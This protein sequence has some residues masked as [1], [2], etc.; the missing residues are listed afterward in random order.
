MLFP[1]GGY[2][3]A[4]NCNLYSMGVYFPYDLSGY[5]SA[6]LNCVRA[7]D[8]SGRSQLSVPEGYP[9]AAAYM[10]PLTTGGLA[11]VP[12]GAA[13]PAAT[14]SGMG[15][16]T[17]SL[18]GASTE[19]QTLKGLGNRTP[20]LS[21]GSTVD[22]SMGGGGSLSAS[23]KPGL[24]SAIDIEGVVLE[25]PIEGAYSAKQLLRIIAAILA[26]KVSGGPG[27]PVFRDVN[28][29]KNRVSGTADADG[30]R[31]AVTLDPD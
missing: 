7:A 30:N 15:T 24:V 26:G 2:V 18:S 31:T 16:V 3:D 25:T 10:P 11:A 1:Q 28:D 12:A 29:T 21:G 23:I 14:V 13:V 9:A 6:L 27:T 17:G 5:G 8:M 4:R 20:A 19:G 22:A